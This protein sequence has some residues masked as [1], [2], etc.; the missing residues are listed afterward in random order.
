MPEGVE[1]SWAAQYLN[2]RFK[3]NTLVSIDILEGRYKNKEP[4]GYTK[5][6]DK[7]NDQEIV[8]KKVCNKGKFLYF[9]FSDGTSNIYIFNTFGL[10]GYWSKEL[11]QVEFVFKGDKVKKIYY[12]DQRRFGTFSFVFNEKELKNKLNSLAPDFLKETFDWS[13]LKERMTNYITLTNGKVSQSRCNKKIVEVL[14]NQ[15]ALGSG[16]GNYLV[17]EIL[18]HAKI[19]PHTTL[20]KIIKDEKL[21]KKLSN[22]I[23]YIIKLSYLKSY[24]GYMEDLDKDMYSYITNVRS[25][26]SR[27]KLSRYNYHPDVKINSSFEFIVY[28]QKF[29]KKGNKV[30]GEKI[31]NKRT[32]YW[33]P[34]VQ[35]N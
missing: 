11:G 24:V 35:V 29:D 13:E 32:T 27:G 6:I 21:T 30:K 3:N 33:V 31:V 16:I 17:A 28:Q 18:Y 2:N 20:N 34:T 12:H 26:V 8:L 7:L 22:A 19:S 23:K 9:H 25:R 14:M 1:V 5:M 4:P 10:T 15:Q